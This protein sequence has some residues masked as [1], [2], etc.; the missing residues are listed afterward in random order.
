M[1]SPVAFEMPMIRRKPNQLV[2][3]DENSHNRPVAEE[4]SS[5]GIYTWRSQKWWKQQEREK[6]WLSI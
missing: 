3:C 4:I 2:E 1:G 5:D 6:A